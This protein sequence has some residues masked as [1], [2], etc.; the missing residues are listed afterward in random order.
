MDLLYRLYYTVFSMGVITVGMVPVVMLMRLL[1]YKASKKYIVYMWLLL[2]S[3]GICPVSMSSPVSINKSL[4]RNFHM[5]LAQTGLKIEDGAGIMKGWMSVYNNRISVNKSYMVCSVIWCA[6]VGLLL[7][8]TFVRQIKL[9]HDLKGSAHIYG[10]IYQNGNICSPVMKGVFRLKIYIPQDMKVKDLKYILQHFGIHS[11]RKDGIKRFFAFMVAVVQWFN[12]FIW[13]AYYFLLGD[14]EIAADEDVARENGNDSAKQ[15]AQELFNLKEGS[16]KGK[17]SLLTFDEKF[18]KKRVYRLLYM[19]P[20]KRQYAQLAVLVLFLC[21]VWAFFLRPLQIL[22]N[23]GTWQIHGDAP[24][25]VSG[26]MFSENSGIVVASLKTAAPSG[27]GRTLG[28]VMTSGTYDEENGYTGDFSLRLEDDSGI[29]LDS[30]D[31]SFIFKHTKEDG[32]NFESQPMLY[33]YDYNADGT[34]EIVIGQ[35]A[36]VSRK[37]WKEIT[38]K[39]KKEGGVLNEYYIWSIEETSLE[40]VSGEIYDNSGKPSASC[41]FGMPDQTTGVIISELSGKNIYYVWNPAEGV[42]ERKGLTKKQLRKYRTGNNGE[43]LTSGEKNT[44]KLESDG[45][46]SMEVKTQKDNTG[47]EVIKQIV[48]NPGTSSRKMDVV[49]GYFCD[50]QWA[51]AADNENDRYAVLIYNGLQAQTFV[52]YDIQEQDIYYSQEDGNSV[53]GTVFKKYNGDDIRFSGGSPAVYTLMEKD[54]SHLKIGFAANTADNIMVNGSYIYD[55]DAEKITNF[56]YTQEA[57][58]G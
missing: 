45:R 12:P 8:F 32:M 29:E 37:E 11:R 24:G 25:P 35:Q 54:G 52:V 41:Q 27:L 17:Q 58:T 28:L 7:I 34:N 42:Y 48:L 40:R 30:T 26:G 15:Y 33:I 16:F 13:A 36:H 44:H 39:R 6:G 56:K 50:L 46:V 49:E 38:G 47:S 21:C 57:G 3:R 4:S 1:L 53:L 51:A 31:I 9:S 10:N 20:V 22:W 19:E 43:E 18:L 23:G 14:I 5:L 55:T 2:F